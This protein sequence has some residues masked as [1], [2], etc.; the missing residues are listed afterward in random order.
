MKILETYLRLTNPLKYG[1]RKGMKIGKGVSLAGKAGVSF[2]SEPYLIELGDEVRISGNVKFFT[3]DGGTWAYRDFDGY[4]DVSKFGAIKVGKRTFIGN[5]VCIL[6]GVTIGERCVIGAGSVV[7][8]NVESG[9]VVAGNP[10]KVI[11]TT[12]EYMDKCKTDWN[13]FAKL[14]LD[15]YKTDKRSYLEERF[16]E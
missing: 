13:S 15:V 9:M 10:A 5:S 3:H 8:H 7:T 1:V 14:S 4:K 11:C 6:P 2:G 16:L 12:K